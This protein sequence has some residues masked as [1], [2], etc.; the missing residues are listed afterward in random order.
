MEGLQGGGRLAKQ[1]GKV[2]GATRKGMKPQPQS[3]VFPHRAVAAFRAISVLRSGVSLAARAGPPFLPPSLPKTTAAGFFPVSASISFKARSAS[4][5]RL[6][7]LER[8]GTGTNMT[9]KRGGCKQKGVFKLR[10][11]FL[12]SLGMNH[13]TAYRQVERKNESRNQSLCEKERLRRRPAR[14]AESG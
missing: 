14:S 1:M 7:F 6:T 2:R 13:L 11:R 10:A 8:L 12:A 4:K 5:R 3:R 9:P